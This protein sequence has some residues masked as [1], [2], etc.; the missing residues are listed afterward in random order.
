[1]SSPIPAKL[2]KYEIKEEIGRGSMGVVYR[3]YDPYIDRAVA[4]KVALADALRDRETSER[5]RR[6][7]FNEAHTAGMLRH[8]NI[9]EIFDAGVD[10]DLCYIV[11]ELVADGS[12]LRSYTRAER[13]LPLDQ[14]AGIVFECARALDYAHRQGVIHRDIKPS[15]ILLTADME[16]KIADFSI[17][18]AVHADTSQTMPMGFVGSPR[19]MSPEQVHEDTITNQTD[20]FSLGIVAYELI[21]GHHPFG[22]ETFSSLVHKIVNEDPTPMS[23]FRVGVPPMLERI[24]TRALEKTTTRRYRMGLEMASDLSAVFTHLEKPHE[25]VS[26]REKFERVKALEFFSGFPDAEIWEIIRASVWIDA[27][28][29]DVIVVEGEHEDSFFIIVSG[30]TRVSKG[31]HDL[32][33]LRVG[34]CF[35]EMGY[36]SRGRRTATVTAQGP[37]ALMK[38]NAKLMEQVSRDCQL[39]FSK[40]FLR[41]LIERLAHTTEM[42]VRAGGA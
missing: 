27:D 5:F 32:G 36:L 11:M 13:L 37:V 39:R 18:H 41:I 26:A 6:M 42:M 28:V 20:L 15:N 19:Y 30:D 31:G 1:M 23:E 22:G 38:I 17:A 7:F 33:R 2:G 10:E 16:V 24:V 35:G 21:T 12:T 8:P 25:D 34:D 14:A 29:E 40:V 4:L 9:L 3:A